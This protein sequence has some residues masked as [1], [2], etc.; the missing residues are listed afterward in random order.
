[1]HGNRK[2]RR[3]L[4]PQTLVRGNAHFLECH[5]VA[6]KSVDDL[7]DALGFSFEVARAGADGTH[8]PTHEGE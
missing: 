1:V 3:E 8:V 4:V 5:E 6:A 7:F 2:N